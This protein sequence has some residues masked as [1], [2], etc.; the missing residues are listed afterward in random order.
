MPELHTIFGVYPDMARAREALTALERSG[1]EAAEISLEGGP[2]EA[3][4]D[5][6][7]TAE[8]DLRVTTHVGGRAISGLAVGSVIGAAVGLL[9]SAIAT[10]GFGPVVWAA[11]IGGGVAGGAVGGV[12]VGVGTPAMSEEWELT[13]E[14]V[15]DGVRIRVTSEDPGEIARAEGVLRDK[16]AIAVERVGS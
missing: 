7:V 13:H 4:A 2:V 6:P 3:A 10:G 1:I 8:R 5:D 11:V 14:P 15:S 9:V 12:M 16:E